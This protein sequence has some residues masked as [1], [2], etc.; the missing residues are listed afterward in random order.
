MCFSNAHH[1]RELEWVTQQEGKSWVKSMQQLLI[2]IDEMI[3]KAGGALPETNQKE[4]QKLYRAIVRQ[5]DKECPPEERKKARRGKQKQ[6]KERNLIERLGDFEGEIRRFMCHPLA[7]F[8]N[9]Q[10]ER[11]IRMSKVQQ[12]IRACFRSLEDACVLCRIRNYLSTCQKNHIAPTEASALLFQNKLS[13][14]LQ[15]LMQL[16]E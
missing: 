12:K 5:A 6:S 3:T 9:N 14:V 15:K 2:D 1:L 7:P 4:R 10:G 8:T 16:A 13:Y 11:D